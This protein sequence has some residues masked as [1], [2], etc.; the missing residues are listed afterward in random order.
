[1]GSF[2]GEFGHQGLA[3]AIEHQ[4]DAILLDVMMPGMDGPTTFRSSG[5]IRPRPV[6]CVAFD[7]K[8]QSSDQ[9]RFAD[10]GVEA[11]LLKPFDPRPFPTKLPACWVGARVGLELLETARRLRAEIIARLKQARYDHASPRRTGRNHCRTGPLVDPIP[12]ADSERIAVLEKSAQRLAADASPSSSTIASAAAHKLAGVL[13]TFG[14]T[15]GTVLAREL[16]IMYSRENGP[17]SEMAD[18][19]PRPQWNCAP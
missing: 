17:D 3:R 18:G 2:C 13:G 15:R 10:L 16:E 1:M 19:W 14:L 7:A 5:R 9:R 6:S 11:I 4:P 8:V 12:S